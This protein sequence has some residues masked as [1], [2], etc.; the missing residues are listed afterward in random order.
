MRMTAAQAAR[1]PLLGKKG[2]TGINDTLPSE[3]TDTTS[4]DSS[5]I[6]PPESALLAA[7][8]N[9]ERGTALWLCLQPQGLG[10]RPLRA[11]ANPY[12]NCA[13]RQTQPPEPD[14]PWHRWVALS[15]LISPR[16]VIC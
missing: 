16:W 5:S 15:G 1:L 3:P 4:M 2:R 7:R 9:V 13:P 14:E 11:A 6:P 12:G 8:R 10:R